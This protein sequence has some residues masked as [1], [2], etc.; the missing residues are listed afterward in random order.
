M[1]KDINNDLSKP[2]KTKLKKY[3]FQ[4]II[5]S[6]NVILLYLLIR[7]IIYPILYTVFY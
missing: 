3:T 5:T 2:K 4:F 1:V 6:I 7:Y